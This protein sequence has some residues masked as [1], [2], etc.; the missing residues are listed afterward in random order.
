[1]II[2]IVIAAGAAS[3]VVYQETRPSSAPSPSPPKGWTTLDGAWTAVSDAFSALA[4]GS[5]NISFAEGVAADGHWSP[6]ATLFNFVGGPAW[7]ACESQLSGI[8]SLTFWNAS[9]YPATE[10][11]TDFTSGAAPLWTFIF[12]GT[13]TLTFVA[14]W[15]LGKVILNAAL[16]PG[17]VCL[18]YEIF[19]PPAYQRVAPSQELNSDVIAKEVGAEAEY[20]SRIGSTGGLTPLPVP[21]NPGVALYLPGPQLLPYILTGQPQWT[22]AY[23]T[24][25]L[26]GFYGTSAPF[27]GYLMNSTAVPSGHS[28]SWIIGPGPCY[29]TEYLVRLNRTAVVGA[30]GTGGQYFEWKTNVT[31]MTSAVPSH[32]K[33]SDLS[34]SLFGFQLGSPPP[35]SGSLPSSEAL[36]GPGSQNLTECPAPATGWYAVL[37]SPTGAWLDSYPTSPNGTQWAIPDVP[38]SSGDLIAFVGSGGYPSTD[39]I[40]ISNAS[41]PFAFGGDN[42]VGP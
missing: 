40:S 33:L 10:S 29:D 3:Y 42:L 34:T 2:A 9:H 25:G 7:T 37:L 22:L 6:P 35:S 19:S 26:N 38:V 30:P 17:S 41:E 8:S 20:L 23:T 28:Y 31:F 27:T 16:G 39:S 1:M 5:W 4:N 18:Q 15:F 14:S 24:C 36:C 12:N 11:A 32:W 13:G 21:P